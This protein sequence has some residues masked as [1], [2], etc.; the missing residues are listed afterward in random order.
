ATPLWL[1][2][3]E[4]PEAEYR[5]QVAE[6][7]AK[8]HERGGKGLEVTVAPLTAALDRPD[9]YPT[10][11][12]V[13]A[14]TLVTLDAREAA[15]SPVQQAPA[16]GSDLREV[17]EPA[18]ARWDY[19]PARA[20][21]LER[22]RTPDTPRRSLILAIQGLGAVREGEAAARLREVALAE[23]EDGPVRL[24]AARALAR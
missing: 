1:K 8:A 20:V 6:A 9:Q 10:V 22:L 17:V 3:L 4:R 13:I 21:W 2:A 11:R 15:P 14:R 24:E 23:L 7:V 18:L 19:R 16:G 12:P 5:C